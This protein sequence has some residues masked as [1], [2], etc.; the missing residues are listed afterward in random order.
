MRS[1]DKYGKKSWSVHLQVNRRNAVCFKEVLSQAEV[2]DP[3]GLTLQQ[4]LHL[5]FFQF[6]VY[7]VDQ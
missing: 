2:E 4:N 6:S 5:H 7:L 1:L 3:G